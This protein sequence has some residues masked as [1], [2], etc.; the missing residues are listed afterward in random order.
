MLGGLLLAQEL[1]QWQAQEPARRPGAMASSRTGRRRPVLPIAGKR[2][3]ILG[4]LKIT[5]VARVLSGVA[6]VAAGTAVF[7][8]LQHSLQAASGARWM[9]RDFGRKAGRVGG[10]CVPQRFA[11]PAFATTTATPR[12]STQD[13]SLALSLSLSLSL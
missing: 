4:Y 13:P 7:V 8:V 5:L 11:R 3:Q 6:W 12:P 9:E 1:A 10:Q 2:G